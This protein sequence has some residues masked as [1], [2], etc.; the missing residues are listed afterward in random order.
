MLLGEV[1]LALRHEKN[2]T[3]GTFKAE[4]IEEVYDRAR[5]IALD[6]SEKNY[7]NIPKLEFQKDYEVKRIGRK[8]N[9][10]FQMLYGDFDNWFEC[11]Y[12]E[13]E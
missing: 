11:E 9:H 4:S 5:T 3:V 1:T 2:I 7:I 12:W 13:A 8:N 6:Y 10:Y